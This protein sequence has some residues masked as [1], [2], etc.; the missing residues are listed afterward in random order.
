MEWSRLGKCHQGRTGGRL[1]DGGEALFIAKP[2][3]HV[4]PHRG[5][6]RGLKDG[7]GRTKSQLCNRLGRAHL[8]R[9]GSRRRVH[10][11]T[12]RSR[13]G[14]LWPTR[15]KP[16]ARITWPTRVSS[17]TRAKRPTRVSSP[18]RMTWRRGHL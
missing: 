8:W 7:G 13:R 14:H 10:L 15:E 6:E 11:Y 3:P 16:D 2:P 12:R 9:S 5:G 17:W 18:A 4:A 1:I